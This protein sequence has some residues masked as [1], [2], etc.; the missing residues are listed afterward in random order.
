[1]IFRTYEIYNEE[2]IFEQ[3]EEINEEINECFICWDNKNDETLIKLTNQNIYFNNCNCNIIIHNS[4]LQ[5]WF[6]INK[7]CPICRIM[8]IKKC[9]YII[10]IVKKM[11]YLS[12]YIFINI[13]IMS[14]NFFYIFMLFRLYIF[15]ISD[16][17]IDN[18]KNYKNY[19][20]NTIID[21]NLVDYNILNTSYNEYSYNLY[22]NNVLQK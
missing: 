8:M 2:N 20:N 5:T 17:F 6:E 15:F 18:Y 22:K 4:C 21:D 19:Y 3:K 16:N 12:S 14:L 9:N 1:M 13:F 11:M 10:Y 7:S